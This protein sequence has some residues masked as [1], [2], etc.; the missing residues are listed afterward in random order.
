MTISNVYNTLVKERNGATLVIFGWNSDNENVH[1]DACGRFLNT[2]AL[3][4]EKLVDVSVWFGRIVP[5][6]PHLMIKAK[7]TRMK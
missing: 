2:K 5:S 3:L 1:V 4:L 7:N 6:V